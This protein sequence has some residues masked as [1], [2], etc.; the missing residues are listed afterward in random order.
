MSI[1][2]TEFV[3][4][5]GNKVKLQLKHNDGSF[6]NHWHIYKTEEKAKRM[7]EWFKEA[8]EEAGK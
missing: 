7:Y 5:I 6:K 4:R 2:R 8:I 1:E 3:Q